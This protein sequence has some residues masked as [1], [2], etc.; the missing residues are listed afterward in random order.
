MARRI[1]IGLN[2]PQAAAQRVFRL[3]AVFGLF[4]RLFKSQGQFN[5][6]RG[7]APAPK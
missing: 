2:A 1:C 5:C 3:Q 6:V 7:N 4:K